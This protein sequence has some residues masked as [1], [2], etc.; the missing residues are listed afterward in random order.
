MTT[1]YLW[2]GQFEEVQ[3]VI[4]EGKP[5]SME[6][7]ENSL[8]G[9]WAT[10]VKNNM[11]FFIIN[12]A[13]FTKLCIL[14]DD[15]EPCFEGASVTKPVVSANFSKTIDDNFK[16]TLFSMMKDLQ[17]ALK[18]GYTM[19]QEVKLPVDEFTEEIQENEPSEPVVD[20]SPVAEESLSNPEETFEKAEEEVEQPETEF[21]D[22]EE[23]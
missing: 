4:D 22:K 21:K 13:I 1:G 15:T 6:L 8:D 3:S 19:E 17:D 16:K 12:D 7:D 5:Q 11:E 10:N 14:G 18:G 9:H 23:E 2:T 20:E